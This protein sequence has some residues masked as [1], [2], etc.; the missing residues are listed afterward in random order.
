M[1]WSSALSYIEFSWR[2]NKSWFLLGGIQNLW[3]QMFLS[4]RNGSI[5]PTNCTTQNISPYDTFYINVVAVVLLEPNARTMLIYW[6]ADCPQIKPFSIKSY[7]NHPIL[8]L[9]IINTCNKYGNTN[10]W[11]YSDFLRRFTIRDL[12]RTSNEFQKR[13]LF[14]TTKISIGWSLVVPSQT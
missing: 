6:K 3:L 12:V 5:T 8:S 4:R 14:N 10:K 13:L 7:P 2:C 9:R 11:A 1:G